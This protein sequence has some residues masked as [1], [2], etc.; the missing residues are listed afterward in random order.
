[1]IINA[2]QPTSEEILNE[3]R[4]KTSIQE[5]ATKFIRTRN[6]RDFSNLYKRLQPGISSF[7]WNMCKGKPKMRKDAVD[8]IVA[9]TFAKIYTKVDQYDP[10]WKFS[11]WAF[12]IARNL[13]LIE[14][15]KTIRMAKREISYDEVCSNMEYS[16]FYSIPNI[17]NPEEYQYFI[18]EDYLD[19]AY[20]GITD[21][22]LYEVVMEQIHNLSPLYKDIL[23]DREINGLKYEE[24]AI[25]YELPLNTLKSR[26]RL[27]RE[28]LRSLVV[29]LKTNQE[30]RR[31]LV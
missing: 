22:E 6:H 2:T 21:E 27:G 9:Q 10:Y 26:I 8:S 5:L 7:V 15:N 19:R 20:I 1:M 4:S 14:L 3:N 11:T 29:N 16:D 12:A 18:D 13:T 24:L 17:L 31:I 28:R 30:G 25:K 23:I